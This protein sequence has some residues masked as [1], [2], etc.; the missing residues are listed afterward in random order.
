MLIFNFQLVAVAAM[1]E[2]K[3]PTYALFLIPR[4]LGILFPYFLS[5]IYR[6]LVDFLIQQRNTIYLQFYVHPKQL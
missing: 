2:V 1:S 6:C 4:Y 5:Y 3:P